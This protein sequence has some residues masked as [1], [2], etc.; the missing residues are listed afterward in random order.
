M[1]TFLLSLLE[2]VLN[3]IINRLS[4]WH[5]DIQH[6]RFESEAAARRE[7][8]QSVEDAK[9]LERKARQAANKPPPPAD[10]ATNDDAFGDQTWNRK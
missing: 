7:A 1:Y 9:E 6:K 10:A 5:K 4:Q 8:M 3:V 2:V